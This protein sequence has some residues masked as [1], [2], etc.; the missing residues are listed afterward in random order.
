MARTVVV[1]TARGITTAARVTAAGAKRATALAATTATAA[2]MATMAT[3]AKTA[4]MATTATMMPNGDDNYK[5]QA[6]TTA[7][8]MTTVARATVTGAK[9]RQQR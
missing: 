5:N 9:G 4:R 1:T 8:V 6:A 7:R 3:A 2:T